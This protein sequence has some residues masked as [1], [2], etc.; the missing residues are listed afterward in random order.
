MNKHQLQTIIIVIFV[1]ALSGCAAVSQSPRIQHLNNIS[2]SQYARDA[3]A[4]R[5]PV[6]IP[7]ESATIDD[8]EVSYNLLYER[9]AYYPGYRLTVIIRNNTNDNLT[10]S[11]QVV[12]RDATGMVMP[13]MEQQDMLKIA[14][15]LQGIDVPNYNDDKVRD[16]QQTGSIV[17]SSGSSYRYQG[18]TTERPKS[19]IGGMLDGVAEGRAKTAVREAEMSKA[20]GD[21]LM[22]L[23]STYW[24]K[25]FVDVPEYSSVCG[26]RWFPASSIANLPLSI[27]ITIGERIYNFTTATL[28]R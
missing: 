26:V 21:E 25:Q 19:A 10:V 20:R 13:S 23:G 3:V 12:L 14:A 1:I 8:F 7:Y 4:L 22:M 9:D 15:Q 6:N 11:P 2:K 24:L 17:T 28:L 27:Q 5:I 16:T 18:T